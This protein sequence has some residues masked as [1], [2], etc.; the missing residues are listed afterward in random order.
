MKIKTTVD[1]PLL[2]VGLQDYSVIMNQLKESDS[3]VIK[4]ND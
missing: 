4:N 1:T 3:T 2:M